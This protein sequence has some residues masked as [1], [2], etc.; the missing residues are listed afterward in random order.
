M[1]VLFENLNPTKT[2][3]KKKSR[4]F[5]RERLNK[6]IQR[7]LDEVAMDM[8]PPVDFITPEE[9][10]KARP[11]LTYLPD[12]ITAL[13]QSLPPLAEIKEWSRRGYAMMP[14]PPWAMSLLDV[15][16]LQ[17]EHFFTETGA[18]C[19]AQGFI[20]REKTSFFGWLAI[21]KTSVQDSIRKDWVQQR[22]LISAFEGVPNVAEVGWFITTYFQVRGVRLFPKERVRTSSLDAHNRRVC[23]GDFLESG[24]AVFPDFN[25]DLRDPFIGI[26]SKRNRCLNS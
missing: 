5:K 2:M 4:V 17:A 8:V 15:Y 19:A 25:N 21:R 3:K 1:K 16:H 22:G 18:F 10:M 24:L 12:Q 23:I 26:A 14:N 20:R 11:S 9:V 7:V 6:G 13:K